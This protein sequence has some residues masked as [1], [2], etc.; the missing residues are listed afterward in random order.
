[1]RVST[2]VDFVDQAAREVN[3]SHISGI[4]IRISNRFPV[5]PVILMNN[6]GRPCFRHTET[7]AYLKTVEPENLVCGVFPDGQSESDIRSEKLRDNS[8]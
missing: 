5:I 6:A 4:E 3:A 7:G 2:R 1:M 8:E